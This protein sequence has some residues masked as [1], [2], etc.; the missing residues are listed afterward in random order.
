[1]AITVVRVLLAVPLVVEGAVVAVMV[2]ARVVQLHPHVQV[3]LMAVVVVV[4][5]VVVADVREGAVQVAV[6]N[7]RTHQNRLHALVVAA[8]AVLPA[9]VNVKPLVP[10]FA[11]GD[12]TGETVRE[13]VPEGAQ[14]VVSEHV[15]LRV[16][17]LA[18]IHAR[19]L[20]QVRVKHIVE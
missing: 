4:L 13:N 16:T 7:V 9:L 11:R 12:V 10:R 3:A 5:E 15:S 6:D 19:R 17:T 14:A 20:V 2:V 18:I 1:M 8:V